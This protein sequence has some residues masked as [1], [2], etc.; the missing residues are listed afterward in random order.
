MQ[1]SALEH[2]IEI[3]QAGSYYGA[4]KACGKISAQ[5][6]SKLISSLEQELGVR[7]V[8]ASRKGVELT[9][10]GRVFLEFAHDTL[11][12]YSNLQSRFRE[13]RCPA[14]P[15]T[16][17]IYATFYAATVISELIPQGLIPGD[18]QVCEEPFN[19]IVDR[20]S[21]L[22]ENEMALVDLQEEHDSNDLRSK[23]VSFKGLIDC[24]PRAVVA[25]GSD[26][27]AIGRDLELSDLWGARILCNS[28][29][30]MRRK[31]R[32]IID[33]LPKETEIIRLSSVR[34]LWE[35]LRM[36][37]DCVFIA[38]SIQA[39]LTPH[40]QQPIGEGFVFIPISVN[41]LP[42]RLGIL[43]ARQGK[44]SQQMAE[45]SHLLSNVFTKLSEE[46]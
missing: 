23:G 37:P 34:G 46:A 12:S 31:Y 45:F 38:D 40:T 28:H 30:E 10:E 41:Y 24:Q 20:A 39:S 26:L 9:P 3:A 33:A 15:K 18:I 19:D 4:E 21:H 8:K 32:K 11:G 35:Y 1:L 22:R 29:P 17:V 7:L 27:A 5:A 25:A 43:R 13:S 36:N 6:Y 42:A 44:M 16:P 2:F 14:R